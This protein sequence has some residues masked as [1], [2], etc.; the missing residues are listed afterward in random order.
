[1]VKL[2]RRVIQRWIIRW[3]NKEFNLVRI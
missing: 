2:L 1:M 3:N